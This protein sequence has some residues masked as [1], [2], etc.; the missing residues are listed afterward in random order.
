MVVCEHCR[1]AI[2]SRGERFSVQPLSESSLDSAW[3]DE[4]GLAWLTCQWC[5]DED[6]A[7]EMMEIELI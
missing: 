7:N 6:V 4:D 2:A 1:E 5:K 3:E